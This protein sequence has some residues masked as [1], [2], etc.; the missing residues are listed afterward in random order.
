[1]NEGGCARERV[2]RR[3]L[4][5]LAALLCVHATHAAEVTVQMRALPDGGL[6]EA[7]AL[8]H[9]DAATAWSVLTDYAGYERF[10]PG[11]RA[12][13]VLQRR[14]ATVTVEQLTEATVALFRKPM[15]L[16]YEIVEDPPRG[17][18]SRVIGG[19]DCTLDSAYALA[20]SDAD[21]RLTYTGRFG[22]SDDLRAAFEAPAAMQQIARHLQSLADEIERRAAARNAAATTGDAAARVVRT[23]AP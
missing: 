19:C 3:T 7:R 17:L 23:P 12:S 14:G 1:M 16:T 20:A 10:V 6:I 5:A 9:A 21:A 4:G 11:L 15:T 2:V 8:L 18:H 13:R 22:A